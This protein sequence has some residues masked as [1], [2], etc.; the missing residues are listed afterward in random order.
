MNASLRTATRITCGIAVAAAVGVGALALD[1]PS[2]SPQPTPATVAASPSTPA[3]PQRVLHYEAD[4]LSYAGAGA[5][6]ADAPVVITGIVRSIGPGQNDNVP[7]DEDGNSLPSL[8]H[9]EV[10]VDVVQVFQAIA[11]P[12]S[13]ITV[14][15]LGGSTAHTRYV[16]EG[17]PPLE[18]G[19][20]YAMFLSPLNGIYYPL[21]GGAAIGKQAADGSYTFS[22]ELTGT[23]PLTIT[24][25][26]LR[27]EA[28]QG[29]SPPTGSPTGAPSG[30][31]PGTAADTT[32]PV[33]RKARITRGQ[34]AVASKLA[35]SVRF[36]FSLSETARVEIL[37]ERL[38][39]TRCP[40]APGGRR[41]R[42]TTTRSAGKLVRAR[43]VKGTKQV[44]F[45]GRVNGRALRRGNYQARIFATDGAGNRS[46]PVRV[47]FKII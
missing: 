14:S 15:V 45:A 29:V 24:E 38:V 25:G 5:L 37:L 1:T 43:L 36:E 35:K 47:L 34:F 23:Q 44:A 9:T 21:A 26:E 4:H 46:R 20:T 11:P 39:R 2:D 31:G 8:V 16:Y 22:D 40:T 42:C 7:P 3:A 33:V 27:R 41:A 19:G 17:A 18:V 6:F 10:K 32:A 12:P 30:T 13:T 28:P